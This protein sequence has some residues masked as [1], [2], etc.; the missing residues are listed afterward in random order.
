MKS[1]ILIIP[2]LSAAVLAGGCRTSA[3][4]A[5]SSSVKSDTVILTS[6]ATDTL[7]ILDSVIRTIAADSSVVMTERERLVYRSRTLRD[8]VYIARTDSVRQEITVETDSATASLKKH[9]R[10]Y[11]Y[12][13]CVLAGAAGGWAVASK[14]LRKNK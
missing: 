8:T 3:Y 5:E 1:I 6:R 9:F 14:I 7:W 11:T 12:L 2:F 10:Y 4:I 13:I